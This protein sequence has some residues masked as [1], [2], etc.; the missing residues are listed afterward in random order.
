MRHVSSWRS[1]SRSDGSAGPLVPC[2]LPGAWTPHVEA[3]SETDDPL[4]VFKDFGL[5]WLYQISI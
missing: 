4:L 5:L 1:Y 2:L 3:A